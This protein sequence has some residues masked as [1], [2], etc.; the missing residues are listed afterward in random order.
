MKK[1]LVF[2]VVAIIIAAV[3]FIFFNKEEKKTEEPKQQPLAQ[4]KNT[5]AFN[6]PFNDFL[7]GYYQ[8]K[9]ALVEWDT[10]KTSSSAK[11][12]ITLAANVPYNELKADSSIIT[13]AKSFSESVVAESMG[14]TGETTI[15]GKR[16]SFYT[17][18]ENLYNLIRTVRYDQQVI[19]HIK[20]PMA[21]NDT[22]EAY[23]LS[24]VNQVI[25]PYL[26]KQHPKYHAA[27]INCGNITDS[28]DYRTS[29]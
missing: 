18:S 15:E 27:M 8:L 28:V 9:D 29:K 19:Y 16:R 10:A 26:G 11:A 22:E 14:I 20:C 1:G 13:T 23:W 3:Y 5:D 24:N 4:S 12:L 25:N 6:K 7:N 17:L 21:F 2:I